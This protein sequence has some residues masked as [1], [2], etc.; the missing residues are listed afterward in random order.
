MQSQPCLSSSAGEVINICDGCRI[1]FVS[2]VELDCTG[3][4]VVALIVPG[5]CKFFG[6]FGQEDDYVHPLGLHSPDGRR[7]YPGGGRGGKGPKALPK[8]KILLKNCIF[9][10]H[11]GTRCSII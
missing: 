3:G 2:D 6:L 7:Y 8:E 11:W 4:N 10:L 5:N 1:G 9:F